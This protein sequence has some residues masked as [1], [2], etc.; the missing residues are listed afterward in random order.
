MN[1]NKIKLDN[2]KR[3]ECQVWSR[4]MGY[5]RPMSQ[6]NKGKAQ[7]AKDRKYFSL[8]KDNKCCFEKLDK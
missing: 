6:Y 1:E 4:V 3:T 5:F 7:E 2:S 8:S